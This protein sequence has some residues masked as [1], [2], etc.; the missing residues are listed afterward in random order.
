MKSQEAKIYD[1][2]VTG[3]NL[4]AALVFFEASNK[5]L[6]LAL[7]S[8]NNFI[9]SSGNA[10]IQLIEPK[11]GINFFEI[12]LR[13]KLIINLKKSFLHLFI[14]SVSEYIYEFGFIK[15]LILRF[16]SGFFNR[17]FKLNRYHHHAEL[18]GYLQPTYKFSIHR[19]IIALV[20]NSVTKGSEVYPHHQIKFLKY[21]DNQTY[22]LQ[23][24]NKLNKKIENL[25]AKRI[26]SFDLKSNLIHNKIEIADKTNSVVYFIYPA[27]GLCID[28]NQILRYDEQLLK[29]IPLFECIYFEYIDFKKEIL[30][31]ENA[32]T[33]IHDYLKDIQIDKNKILTHG[34]YLLLN[35]KDNKNRIQAI[36]F[37]KGK[38]IR[39]KFKPVIEWFNYSNKLA[40][41]LIEGTDKPKNRQSGFGKIVFKGSDIP[42]SDNPLRI[43]EYA[44]EK[45]DEAKQ[46]LNSPMYFKRLF[47]RYGTEVES[48]TEKAY[49]YWN[50]TKS[51]SY[52]W[53][54]AE[55]EYCI[56]HEFCYSV[57]DSV[58]RSEWWMQSQ[59]VNLEEIQR[60]FSELKR[61]YDNCS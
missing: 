21:S 52:S 30:S 40:F 38:Q 19:M 42:G 36:L 2:I 26:V 16:H 60:A 3:S 9:D 46:I 5:E 47:Y 35:D 55:M 41:L 7:I 56:E 34:S 25:Q 27:A 58:Q 11:G 54:K 24:E 44:D 10:Y 1:V 22:N 8:E 23:I 50:E 43:M 31:L 15:N 29:I 53:L 59:N 48:I 28:K 6:K 45:Y 32:L 39:I 37:E 20:T 12:R 13:K 4:Q 49:Q 33:L 18:T 14:S 57:E 61:T 51:S 17:A